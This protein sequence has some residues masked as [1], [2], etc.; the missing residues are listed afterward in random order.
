MLKKINSFDTVLLT[1]KGMRSIE[2][3]EIICKGADSEIACYTRY[4]TDEGN[5]RRL[6]KSVMT[7]AERILKLLND[8]R[9]M[10][11]DGFDGPN[12][13]WVRDGYMFS[14]KAEINEGV[15]IRAQGSNNYPKYYHEFKSTL[16]N[17]LYEED[18]SVNND[19]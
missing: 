17:M 14:F 15:V 16:I 2:E 13:K 5:N 10:K 9:I 18:N 7:A 12:P 8:C 19:A 11:W 6:N 1:I 3:Y 4:Y